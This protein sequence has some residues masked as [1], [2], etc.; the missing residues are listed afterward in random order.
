MCTILVPLDGANGRLFLDSFLFVDY[1]W[2][3]GYISTLKNTVRSRAWGAAIGYSYQVERCHVVERF[4][5]EVIIQFN[6]CNE[7]C[8]SVVAD[9]GL[10][11]PLFTSSRLKKGEVL[12]LETR[13]RR[14]ELFLMEK[15]W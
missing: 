9:K 7:P 6:L 5:C 8:I 14:Y 15:N 2:E 3:E 10:T 13:S 1:V 12:Y 4:V 11:K